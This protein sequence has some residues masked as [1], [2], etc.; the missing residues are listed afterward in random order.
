MKQF[1]GEHR[2]RPL[3]CHLLECAARNWCS[4]RVTSPRLVR[5]TAG[6]RLQKM[7]RLLAISLAALISGTVAAQTQPQPQ[8][9]ARPK[10]GT[11]VPRPDSGRIEAEPAPT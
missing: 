6:L 5:P 8:T 10:P 4:E 9:P 11:I 1:F 3:N 7:T 2:G